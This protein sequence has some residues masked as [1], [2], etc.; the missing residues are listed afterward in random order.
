MAEVNYKEAIPTLK[1]EIENAT[2]ESVLALDVDKYKYG[3]ETVIESD[4]RGI[5]EL[6][7]G[8]AN[9]GAAPHGAARRR[10]A[11]HQFD[12]AAGLFC[13][14]LR[15]VGDG[16]FLGGADVIDAEMLAFVAH[17]HDP[18]HQVVDEA[19]AACLLAA[20]LA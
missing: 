8:L 6:E 3:F 10:L 13:D 15:Q 16:D 11:R 20:A 18:G 19:E 12:V 5:S 7:G 4:P 17:H 2:V 1:E 14:A 9:V